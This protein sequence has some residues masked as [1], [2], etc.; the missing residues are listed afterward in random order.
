MRALWRIAVA[1]LRG[2]RLQTLLLFAVVAVATAGITAGLAQQRSAADR[3]DDAFAQ[4]NGAHVALYGDPGTLE[5]VRRDPQ[6]VQATGPEPVT[7]TTLVDGGDDVEDVEIRGGDQLPEVGVPKLFDGRWLSAGDDREVVVERSFATDRGIEGDRVW[8]RGERGE[9]H[10]EVVGV[11]LDLNDC[12]YPQCESQLFWATDATVQRLAG[13]DV[14]ALLVRIA[15]PEAVE[16]FESRAQARYGAGVRNFEDWKDTRADALVFNDFFAA[17]LAMFGIFLL[18]AAGL[19]ILSAV[20]ARVLARYREL[21]ILK[22]VGFTPRALGLLVLGENLLI[23]AVGV[24]VGVVAGGLLAPSLQ[25]RMAEVLER[26]RATFPVGVL[27]LAAV[28]VFAI[29]AAA[30]ALPAVRAG[31][32]PASRAIARGAAPARARRSRL[33]PLAV[34]LHLGAPTAVGIK[35]AGARPLRAWLSVAALAVTVIAIVTTLA[36]DRTVKDIADD[37]S[38]GGAPQ[39]V[40]IDPRDVPPRDVAA[41]VA[42]APGAAAWFT[43]AERQV[44]VGDETFEVR[45]LGGDL[46]RTGYVIREGRML[47]RPGEIVIGYGLQERL[48]VGVGDRLR[49]VVSERPLEVTVVGR[50]AEAEDSGERAMITFADLRRAE[51]DAAP[52]GFFVRVRDGVD[53]EEVADAVGRAIPGADVAAQEADLGDFDA[54][55]AAFYVISVLVLLVG[56]VNLFASTALGIRERIHDI[57]V[58]KAVGFTPG[59][60]VLSAAVGA[61]AIGGVAAVIGAPAGLLIADAM[62]TTVGREGGIGPEF[63]ASPDLAASVA[64]VTGLVVLAAA[65]GALAARGAARAQ[66]AETLRAE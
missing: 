25:L 16:A 22:A 59:Q 19:V 56:F 12:F 60:V 36:F 4:A 30:T 62:L 63:G 5:R 6:V 10:A 24:G 18:V 34:R 66:V 49:V 37:P 58:L 35:D 51:P 26:G 7:W 55:R 46:D 8:L 31:R 17:F 15:D 40:E 38:L 28:V 52:G 29:V 41:A 47:A 2:R 33:A 61:C 57:A 20:S 32:V 48:G 65:A 42:R 50:Y 11:A 54:F 64:G 53:R 9:L 44:A 23:A 14:G 45:A 1:D 21:G 27:V 39:G 3:W 43:V 13:E